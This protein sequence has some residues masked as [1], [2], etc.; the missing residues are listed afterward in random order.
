V[1][2]AALARWTPVTLAIG[3]PEPTIDWCDLSAVAF[4]EPFF[5]QTL[6]R[7]AKTEPAL[8]RTRLSDLAQ[9]E[10]AAPGRDPDG[11][12]LHLARCGSTLISRLAAQ[13]PGVAVLS[14]PEPLNTLLELDPSQVD[15]T[16]R[17][18]CL[19]LLLRAYGRGRGS[20]AHFLVKLSSWNIRRIALLRHA[21]PAVPWAFVYREPAEVVASLL[22]GPPGWMKLRARPD[23]VEGLLGIAR[24]T[25]PALDEAGFAIH[26]VAGFIEAAL[27]ADRGEAL[28]IDYPSLPGAIWERVLPFFGIACPP[29]TGAR[30]AEAAYW[31]AK[32][33]DRPFSTDGKAKREGLPGPVAAEIARILGPLYR[34]LETRRVARATTRP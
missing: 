30:L 24:D 13:V 10:A 6:A 15:E 8:I 25:V 29:E 18:E 2:A 31:D 28:L 33:P 32:Q 22:A 17:A 1:E 9:V 34:E 5:G 7:I 14:E 12:V 11:F 27:G 21:F 16:V 4:T 23:R 19:R 20:A 3:A 26:A